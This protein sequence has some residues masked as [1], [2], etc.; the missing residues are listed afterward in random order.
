MHMSKPAILVTGGTG[1]LGA[2]TL[3]ELVA[4]G[5]DVAATFRSQAKQ[6]FARKLFDRHFG[7]AAPQNWA[8]V[9]WIQ[10]D[11]SDIF[12]VEH[13]MEG[14]DVVFHIAGMV[15]FRPRDKK[16]LLARNA[17]DTQRL[18][19]EALLRKVS[20]FCQVS[21][22]AALGR[23]EHPEVIDEKRSWKRDP[24]NSFYARSKHAA[25]MEVWRGVE[26][27][28]P[29]VI[30]NPSVILGE[31]IWDSGTASLFS[32]VYKGLRA[33]PPGNTGF[34]GV[35]D[36]AASMVQLW[37][38]GIT[39]ERFILNAE[40]RSWESVL[41][42]IAKELGK[43]QPTQKVNPRLLHLLAKWARRIERFG[44]HPFSLGS[45]AL[46]NAA[47]TNEYKSDKISSAIGLEFQ[48]IDDVIAATA[49][50]YLYHIQQVK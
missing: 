34:V 43:P 40:N 20:Y 47:L 5:H 39:G 15:S 25:E 37:K 11:L 46:K 17:G 32:R 12:A 42:T 24:S 31:G 28:L 14:I 23:S 49:K 26:E 45:D 3:V 50:H 13:A 30:V 2:H 4:S 48:P 21:S 41:T 35:R 22:I 36:V 19:N 8:K 29:A 10:A 9:H 27:G 38:K 33:F 44:I 18:V 7:E 16:E 1:F 6:E